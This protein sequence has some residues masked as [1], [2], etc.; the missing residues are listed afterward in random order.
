MAKYTE[1]QARSAK[2]Y[3]SNF[4]EIKLRMKKEE[5]QRIQED[6]KLSGKSMNQYILDKVLPDREIKVIDK[7]K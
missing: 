3:L 5:R 6:A 2:K 1:A 4:V 7:E